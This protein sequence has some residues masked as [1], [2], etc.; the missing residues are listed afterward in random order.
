MG[1]ACG[2]EEGLAM[3]FATLIH[4]DCCHGWPLIAGKHDMIV[5]PEPAWSQHDEMM[6][7]RA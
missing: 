3:E 7:G 4:P 2:L 6:R 1:C 5:R